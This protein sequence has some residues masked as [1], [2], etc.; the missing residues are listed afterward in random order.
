VK[1]TVKLP[2]ILKNE[3]VQTAIMLAATVIAFIVFWYGLMFTLRT[4]HPLM[5]VASESMRPTLEVGDLIVVQGGL[6]GDDILAAP[7][8]AAQPG[9]IIVFP[10]ER[11]GRTGELIV[12]RA[13]RKTSDSDGLWHFV[14]QG[15]NN[16]V[17]DPR[18]VVE[19]DV[20][21]KVVW[22]VPLLGWPNLLMQTFYGK[23]VIVVLLGILIVIEF[24]PFP[25]REKAEE[26]EAKPL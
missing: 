18:D 22:R 3:K 21:G 8:D 12:H 15:D 1:T 25:K 20:V 11:L 4:A 5:A 17:A 14:T 10:G 7:K 24:I 16:H 6:I 13:I 23:V 9:D 2:P 26:D 19:T